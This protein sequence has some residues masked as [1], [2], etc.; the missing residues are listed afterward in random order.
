MASNDPAKKARQALTQVEIV[1]QRAVIQEFETIQLRLAADLDVVLRQIEQERQTTGNASPAA[2]FQ[3]FR[4][5]E[6]INQ[7]ADSIREASLHLA[8]LTSTAQT[9]AIDVAEAQARQTPEL[10]A[11][12]VHF[13]E[14]ATRELV[15]LAGDGQP[16]STYFAALAA[17]A[18]D[19][20]FDALFFGIASG[21]PNAQIAKEVKEA[22][23]G[24]TARAMTIVRTEMNRSYRESTR[25]FYETVDDVVGWRWLS[26]R[27]LRTCPLCWAMDGRVFKTKTKFGTHPNC[28]CTMVPVFKGEKKQ[29]TG[30][31][32]FAK[33]NEA[34]KLAIL[35]PGRLALYN[36]GAE[37]IDFVELNKSAF[38]IGRNV[39]PLSRT[40]FKPNPR[41][42]VPVNPNAPATPKK[43]SSDRLTPKPASPTAT[44]KVFTAADA[45]KLR[46]DFLKSPAKARNAELE[47]ERARIT[48]ENA[49]LQVEARELWSDKTLSMLEARDRSH[50]IKRKIKV[51]ELKLEAAADAVAAEDRKHFHVENP[52]TLDAVINKGR[53]S[54][55][56]K[57]IVAEA[58][59]DFGRLV[60]GA[61]WSND[62]KRM[63]VNKRTGRAYYLQG[64]IYINPTP[65]GRRTIVH[66]TGHALEKFNKDIL[67]AANE[68]LNYRTAGEKP[69]RLKTLYPTYAYARHETARPD[70]FK[71]AYIGKVYEGIIPGR[72]SYTEVI[73][74]GVE[75][76]Y[77][78]AYK[79][80]TEDPEYFDFIVTVIRGGK[81]QP[82]K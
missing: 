68:F 54:K 76:L 27:D 82:S 20:L 75:Q 64:Q 55:A 5:N 4:L 18:R 6:L 17:P 59:Q 69:V 32:A 49:A 26:A 62:I 56:E 52:I 45:A 28:R 43:T 25:K 42:I 41:T 60:D 58:I 14:A 3:Q 77:A 47:N 21:N 36:Q 8:T 39:R 15:G 66:E 74:M 81:W 65:A 9:A 78:E 34:Q 19:A 23:D 73:S 7:V 63:G 35:G 57:D 51:N 16:L 50:E 44:P 40:T 31:A 33:L 37:L 46:E 30:A 24:T 80:A 38:G 70:K 79:F 72:Q 29:V 48:L 22:L 61:A 71:N 53:F 67:T 12:L 13:D 2:M 10:Q 1:R 11:S